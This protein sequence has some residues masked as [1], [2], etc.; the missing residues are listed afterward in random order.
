[1]V[2]MQKGTSKEYFEVLDNLRDSYVETGRDGVI[3]FAN[4][5]FTREL[6]YE[7]RDQTIQ[8]YGLLIKIKAI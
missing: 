2:K 5:T 8:A 6:G 4:L 7:N 3:C 1:M